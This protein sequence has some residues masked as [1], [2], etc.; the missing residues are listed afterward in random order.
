MRDGEIK[1]YRKSKLKKSFFLEFY[2][3]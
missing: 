3:C 1:H 2:A